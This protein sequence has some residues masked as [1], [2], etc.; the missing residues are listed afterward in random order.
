MDNFQLT[1]IATLHSHTQPFFGGVL[2]P[3][4]LPKTVTKYPIFFFCNSDLSQEK[5]SHWLLIYLKGVNSAPIFFDSI[6]KKPEEYNSLIQNFLIMQ[7]PDY[8]INEQRVQA[9]NTSSCGMY[10]L[11]VSDLLC[12]DLT[13][14]EIM[15]LFNRGDLGYN[16]M[17]VD[18]YVNGHM[19]MAFLPN[20]HSQ[21]NTFQSVKMRKG[22]K[23]LSI[24]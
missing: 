9:Y 12:Q 13:L 1:R 20:L 24:R 21:Q 2:N 22:L 5:G 15:N 11:F 6:G 10:C 16:E 7:G 14:E 3:D 8:L 4:T 19:L 17:L 18:S 23:R